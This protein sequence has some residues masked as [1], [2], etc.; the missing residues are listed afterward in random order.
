MQ[1]NAAVL[2]G[3]AFA[4]AEMSVARYEASIPCFSRVL[5]P[6]SISSTVSHL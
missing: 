5:V 4:L 6:S 2:A 1:A 3:W